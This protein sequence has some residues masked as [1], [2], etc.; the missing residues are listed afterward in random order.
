MNKLY[1][2][3]KLSDSEFLSFLY[4]ERERYKN[5][6]SKSGWSLWAIVGSMFALV[7]FAYNLLKSCNADAD[8]T[9]CYC[10]V[11]VF[12]P[13]VLYITYIIERKKGFDNGD[14][15]HIG[16]LGDIAPLRFLLFLFGI[17]L[18]LAIWGFSSNNWDLAV[19]NA[20]AI[21]P[22]A[23]SVITIYIQRNRYVTTFDTFAV[24]STKW[25]NNALHFFIG[26]VILLPLYCASKK[27]SFGFSIEFELGISV[28]VLLILMYLLSN[29]IFAKSNEKSIDVVIEGFL[30]RNW[31]KEVSIA[32]YE[33]IILGLRPTDALQGIYNRLIAFEGS[34]PNMLKQFEEK[35]QELQIGCLGLSDLDKLITEINSNKRAIKDFLEL[36]QDILRSSKELLGL[37]SIIVDADFR[38]MLDLL[39]NRQT[40]KK[41]NTQAIELQDRM[42]NCMKI[43]S[44]KCQKSVCLNSNCPNRRTDS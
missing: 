22:T 34:L 40:F 7:C 35:E 27:L 2:L 10:I 18:L 9:L 5:K 20:I 21:L 6:E 24:S 13:P 8:V 11:C 26:G 31:S 12:L 30:F 32:Q 39:L 3:S 38:T 33:K 15:R 19:L 41:I 1:S 28:V 42:S 16:R 43:V 23:V 29:L 25:L 17:N 37:K 4:S 14:S 36:Y 44:K